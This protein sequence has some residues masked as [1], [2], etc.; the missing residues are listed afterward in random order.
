[1]YGSPSLTSHI[2]QYCRRIQS[3]KRGIFTDYKLLFLLYNTSKHSV[4]NELHVLFNHFDA[5]GAKVWVLNQ[6]VV[7]SENP[8]GFGRTEDFLMHPRCLYSFSP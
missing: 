4:T 8:T 2:A 5:A 7:A 1:M 3:K 6:N